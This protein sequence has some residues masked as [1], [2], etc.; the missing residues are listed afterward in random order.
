MKTELKRS[1]KETTTN[2]QNDNKDAATLMIGY[3]QDDQ[4]DHRRRDKA[5]FEEAAL[6][7]LKE[8]GDLADGGY[9]ASVHDAIF[10]ALSIYLDNMESPVK[11]VDERGEESVDSTIYWLSFLYKATRK[12]FEA[13]ST[14]ELFRRSLNRDDLHGLWI[15]D[16]LRAKRAEIAILEERLGIRE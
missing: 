15:D 12:I 3:P 6:E 7:I 11:T 16:S 10:D 2:K 5:K 8:V 4:S 9:R 14:M 1:A 13:V